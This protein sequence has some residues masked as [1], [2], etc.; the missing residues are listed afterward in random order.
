MIQL[1]YL[2]YVTGRTFYR[3][4]WYTTMLGKKSS[5]QQLRKLLQEKEVKSI[6]FVKWMF[7]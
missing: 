3:F 2:L 4:R 5:L 1:Q 6:L 7:D